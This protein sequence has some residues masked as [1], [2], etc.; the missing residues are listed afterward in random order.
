MPTY[1]ILADYTD[2]G[3]RTVKEAPQR[4]T[5]AKNLAKSFNGRVRQFYLAMGAHD[6]VV[7]AEFPGDDTVAQFVLA[8]GSLGNVRT[9][10]LRL[11]PEAEF[12]QLIK[13][14]PSA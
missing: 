5:A 6:M 13:A 12:K 10:T 3:I 9:S 11:F 8:V 7:I 1:A 14:L 2:Q 4:L